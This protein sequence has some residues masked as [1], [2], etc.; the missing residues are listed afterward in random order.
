MISARTESGYII[1]F[2]P[3]FGKYIATGYLNNG[4]SSVVYKVRKKDTNKFYIAKIISKQDMINKHSLEDVY[5]EILIHK[6]LNHPNIVKHIDTLELRN[7]KGEELIII[8][9]EFC[10]KG[11][12]LTF[13]NKKSFKNKFERKNIE[14]G[15]VDA[16]KYLHA[17]G[18]AHSDIKPENILLDKNM[19]VKLSDFGLC[20]F[21]SN[22]NSIYFK[23]DIWSIGVV[24]YILA[25]GKKPN[26]LLNENGHL[27]V[28]TEDKKLK[29]LVENCTFLDLDKRPGIN[30]TC[31]DDYIDLPVEKKNVDVSNN[32]IVDIDDNFGSDEIVDK[33]YVDLSIDFECFVDM[34]KSKCNKKILKKTKRKVL[35][36]KHVNKLKK[37]YKKMENI[38]DECCF[39]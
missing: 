5:N 33:H 19:N 25:E 28:V 39:I 8:I 37:R 22:E 17:L 18:F 27:L 12:I 34:K 21:C 10:S 3:S 35:Q 14:R 13:M 26:I 38:D 36:K 15:M 31:F 7:S 30:D 24:L 23:N 16:V 9:E 11:D 20:Q 6:S 1:E 29:K 2:D 32:F 4:W